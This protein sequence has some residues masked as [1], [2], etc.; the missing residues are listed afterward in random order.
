M[1]KATFSFIIISLRRIKSGAR[2]LWL[3]KVLQQSPTAGLFLGIATGAASYKMDIEKL[4]MCQLIYLEMKAVE[5]TS[6]S[7]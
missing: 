4:C 3:T 7:T 6:E 1:Y 5:Q 2:K